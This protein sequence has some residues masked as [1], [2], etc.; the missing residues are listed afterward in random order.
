ME[1]HGEQP[2]KFEKEM[3]LLPMRKSNCR[4]SQVPRNAHPRSHHYHPRSGPDVEIFTP[5]LLSASPFLLILM[6]QAV[7]YHVLQKGRGG[8]QKEGLLPVHDTCIKLLCPGEE[9]FHRTPRTQVAKSPICLK[10]PA[11]LPE[12][13]PQKSA[14]CSNGISQTCH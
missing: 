11:A 4:N 3:M 9:T 10:S 14:L 1:I 8:H 2:S 6:F 7:N 13:E 12:Q 5:C